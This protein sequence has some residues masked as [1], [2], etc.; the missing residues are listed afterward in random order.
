MKKYSIFLFSLFLGLSIQ[1]QNCEYLG[2]D[3]YLPCGTTSTTITADFTQCVGGNPTPLETTSYT[4]ASIPFAPQSA[5]GTQVFLGDDQVSGVLPIGFSFCFYGNTY[6]NFYVGSNGWIS[7][8]AGQPAT[9]TSAAIP[10]TAFT[11]P[12]NCVMG[13]WQDWHPGLGGQIRYETQG[14][15]PCRRL[16]VSFSTVPFY[17]CTSTLGTFQIVLYEG[18]NIIENHITSKPACTQ[19]AGGTAVQ[20]IHNLAGTLAVTV[21]GR[22]STAWTATNEGWR[23]TPSG[24]AVTPTIT[25]FQVG[26]ATPIAT[27]VTSI[28]VTPPA[29]GAYYTAA[30]SYSGCYANY[31]SCVAGGTYV[32]D[33][34]FVQPMMNQTVTFDQ[35]PSYCAGFPIPPLPTISNNG[36][37]G[38]WSP[39]INNQT[40]TTYTFTPSVGQ[41]ANTYTQTITITPNVTPTFAP[42]GPFCIGSN[43]P[44]LPS[45]SQNGYSGTWSPVIN[46][47]TTTTYTFT[48]NAGLCAT[49]TNLTITITPLLTPTFTQVGPYCSGAVVPPLNTTSINGV[50]GTWSPAMNNQATTTYTFT[51]NAGQCANQTTM[52]VVIPQ[53]STPTFSSVGPYCSGANIPALPNTSLEGFTGSWSPALNN[54]ATTT[55]TFTSTPGQC[56]GNTSLTITIN[57]NITPIFDNVG[58]FCSGTNINTLPIVSVNGFNGTWSPAIDNTATTTYTFTPASGQCA[59]TTTSTITINPLITPIFNQIGPYCAGGIIPSFPSQST[60]GFTG[61]WSPAPNNTQTTTYTFTSNPNQCATNTTITVEI[62]PITPS[63]TNLSLCQNSLPYSWNGLNINAPGQFQSSL[64]SSNGCDS[65]AILNLTLLPTPTSISNVQICQNQVPFNWNGLSLSTTGMTTVTLTSSQGC[66]SIASLNLT[67]NPMPQVNFTADVSDGCAPVQVIF[68]PIGAT[69]GN[70]QWN[71][72]N[73]V[74]LNNCGSVSTTYNSFGCYDVSL[75]ITNSFGCTS[76]LT[77]DEIVCVNPQ[78]IASFVVNPQQL[79][80]FDPVANFTNTSSGHVSQIWN[81]GDGS[82]T[83]TQANPQHAYPEEEGYYYV[84]LIVANSHGCVDSTVQLVIVE[85][86]VIFYVPN[87]FTPDGDLFNDVFLPVMTAGY[88]IYNYNLLIFDRWGEIIFESNNAQVGWDGSYGGEICQDGTYIWQITFKEIGKDKRRLLRGHINL[89]R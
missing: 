59:T 16:V 71:L 12:K 39:A 3:Q 51:P 55:Y 65:I 52:T 66:D 41:C 68:N 37:T 13:P 9:F 42:Q 46:N 29:G 28:T 69:N 14:V 32:Q 64:S 24:P 8:S 57:P 17:S 22:N 45:T 81:F 30:Y 7:F 60:N 83:S 82:G 61:S 84:T 35:S 5:T 27:N 74:I 44:P 43:I 75:Q 20:G 4:V 77:L 56:S 67:V 40:T 21:A 80:N 86:E 72:G 34:V 70:C 88:D 10:S 78:P 58:P 25:W 54:T 87:T 79:S 2:P 53:N 89:V 76:A 23:Y 1:A 18:T 19:W 33:T 49:A 31:L 15:Q 26:N 62:A 48:P 50:S 85:N 47:Q 63:I 73:G 38:T 36:I 6:S 11:V